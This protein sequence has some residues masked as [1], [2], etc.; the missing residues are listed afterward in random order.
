[1]GSPTL[2]LCEELGQ[3]DRLKQAGYAPLL[4]FKPELLSVGPHSIP[5][6]SGQ[7]PS[8]APLSQHRT[9]A[10][11]L[12]FH[13]QAQQPVPRA[14]CQGPLS[15]KAR[16][17]AGLLTSVCLRRAFF[18]GSFSAELFLSLHGTNTVTGI[19]WHMQPGPGTQSLGLA[20]AM[21]VRDPHPTPGPR[22]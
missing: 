16:D 9:L 1:M 19:A 18:L 21:A 11:R 8:E 14:N 20:R 10:P 7:Q 2:W 13:A 5:N 22:G 4:P 17:K 6:G 3:T 12:W 15:H